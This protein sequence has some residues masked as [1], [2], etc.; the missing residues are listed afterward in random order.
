MKPFPPPPGCEPTPSN[1]LDDD[2]LRF[3]LHST[4]K[5]NHRGDPNILGF[6]SSYIGNRNVSQAARSVGLTS[7]QGNAIRNMT[8][9][10]NAITAI[11]QKM[12]NKYGFDASEVVEKVKEIAGTDPIE[13]VNNDGTFK[14]KMSE[15]AP[16]ARRAIRKFKAKNIYED[17]P[18]GM[19]R[20]VGQLIEVELWDKMKAIEL[21]G[22]EKDLFKETKKVEHGIT[23]QMADVLLE[24]SKRADDRI[25]ALREAKTILIEGK[26][27]DNGS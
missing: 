7:G 27:D 15:I 1:K 6:I 18:N 10:H 17:D 23:E 26:T 8:D 14:T 25:M 24:S 21:L 19:P 5:P 16:E 12:L 4:L 13:F 3:I 22:R 2:E 11:T 9:V 20:V